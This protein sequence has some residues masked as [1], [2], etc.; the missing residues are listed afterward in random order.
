MRVSEYKKAV[1][2][3][4]VKPLGLPASDTERRPNRRKRSLLHGVIVYADGI[5]TLDCTIRDLSETGARI[6][7]PKN[8]Q[9]PSRIFLINVRDRL[10]Y[11]AGVAWCGATEAG[12]AFTKVIP[13]R[14]GLDPSLSF[15]KRI[16][17][18]RAA[19]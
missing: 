16:W 18:A 9:F 7:T 10:V 2:N 17:L 12:L 19:R 13:L 5:H 4:L 14:D 6:V 1:Q 15:L 3:G 8:S 11:D